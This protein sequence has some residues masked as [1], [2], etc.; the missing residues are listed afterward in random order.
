[1]SIVHEQPKVMGNVGKYT[2]D[3]LYGSVTN[4]FSIQPPWIHSTEKVNLLLKRSLIVF[5][6]IKF[7][8]V[9]KFTTVSTPSIHLESEQLI[10][11]ELWLNLSSNGEQTMLEREAFVHSHTWIPFIYGLQLK[12]SRDWK[13]V[14]R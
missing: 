10:S 14:F 6:S 2:W 7:Q 13:P 3:P 9:T 8:G 4:Q 11:R 12:V 5:N 1:M